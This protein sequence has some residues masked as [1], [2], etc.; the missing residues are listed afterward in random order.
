[1][2]ELGICTQEAS[3][4][5]S[6]RMK[7]KVVILTDN[8]IAFSGTIKVNKFVDNGVLFQP[9]EKSGITFWLPVKEINKVIFGDASGL[10]TKELGELF[11][12]LEEYNKKYDLN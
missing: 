4:K 9:S 1:M 11:Q 7:N 5:G 3:L 10:E 12:K 8:E 2:K 6:L